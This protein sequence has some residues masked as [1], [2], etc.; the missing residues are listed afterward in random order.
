VVARLPIKPGTGTQN[1]SLVLKSKTLN[2]NWGFKIN[3]AFGTISD[4]WG[5]SKLYYQKT[6]EFVDQLCSL[7]DLHV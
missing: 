2:L 6:V 1:M 4:T 3:M 5:K 7:S